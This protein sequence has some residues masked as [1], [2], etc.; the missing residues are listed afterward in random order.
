MKLVPTVEEKGH[1]QFPN[2][3]VITFD[4]TQFFECLEVTKLLLL[5]CM[6]HRHSV[7]HKTNAL[8]VL[9]D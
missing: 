3:S 2:G 8:T 4:D 7:T 9:K 1:L 5:E 6:E